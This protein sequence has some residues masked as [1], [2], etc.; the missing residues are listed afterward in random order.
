MTVTPLRRTARRGT[1]AVAALVVAAGAVAA[2]PAA[3]APLSFS[4]CEEKQQQGWEC[5]TLV[6]PL[7]HSGAVPGTV[8]LRVQRLAHDGP[9]HAK[10]LVNIEGGPGASTTGR[11]A[12]T[13]QLLGDVTARNGYDLVLLDTRA[14]GGSTPRAIALGTSRHYS[15]AD[16]VRDLELVRQG[17]GV[18]RLALMGTSYSTLYAAEFARTLPDRTDRVI[19]DSPLGP[20]G[21]TMFGEQTVAGVLPMVRDVCRTAG[22]P[23]S[24]ARTGADLR[25]M[26]RREERGLFWVPHHSW[27]PPP[28][29]KKAPELIRANFG[30]N[31]GA[32]LRMFTSADTQTALFAL[33]PSAMRDAVRGDWRAFAAATGVDKT[34]RF[35]DL[36][37]ND[38]I[39]RITRCL[40][41]R[42]PWPFET[43]AAQRD[44]LLKRAREA[45]PTGPLAPFGARMLVG[46]PGEDCAAFG[47]SGLPTA[48]RGG[49]IPAV[50]GVILQGAWDLRTP[51]SE[52]RAL[53]QAWPTG[54]LVVASGTGHGVLRAA[55]ACATEAVDALLAGKSVDGAACAGTE[56]VAQPL[57]VT[58]N[59]ADLRPLRPAPRAVARTAAAVL[60][61]LRHAELLIAVGTPHGGTTYVGGIRTGSAHAT[62]RPPSIA[63]TIALD[64]Y[65]V[66]PG[67]QLDG[68]IRVGQG[69]S[70][71][72]DVAVGGRHSGRVTIRGGRLTGTIDGRALAVRLPDQLGKPAVTRYG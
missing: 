31:R 6:A 26:V 45:V 42:V 28:R 67:V 49:A 62:R 14:T 54:T 35:E 52:G 60:A 39:N 13:R 70:Y 34:A 7:D 5:A 1:A 68:A 41:L 30:I 65:G 50:P 21:P 38:D 17:L 9:P 2:A 64:E 46:G 18:E 72:V 56:P 47:L 58:S 15:T 3:A 43:P 51:P 22:C 11:S 69:G 24:P 53:A 12:Q 20:G 40:D 4:S 23:G 36:D 33:L 71:R 48:I 63:T 10:A 37:I 59:P 29:G 57:P 66:L 27:M 19:L 32:V 16:T 25:A 55:T 61:T 44:E 8:S